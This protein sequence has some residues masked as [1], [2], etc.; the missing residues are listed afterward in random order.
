MTTK[1][2]FYISNLKRLQ[3]IVGNVAYK[4]N[5]KFN[6]NNDVYSKPINYGNNIHSRA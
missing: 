5:P 1:E 2:I 6:P 3:D 4:I